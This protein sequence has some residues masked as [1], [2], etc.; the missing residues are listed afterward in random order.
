MDFSNM[1]QEELDERLRTL[2]AIKVLEG[3]AGRQRHAARGTG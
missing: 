3:M 1:C 2:A